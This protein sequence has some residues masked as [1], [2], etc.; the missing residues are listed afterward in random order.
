ADY[1]SGACLAFRRNFFLALGG[2]DARYAPAYYED[3]DLAFAVR[4]AGRKVYYQPAATVVH[5]EG[6]T[7]G[8][9]ASTGVKRH[10]AINRAT[11]R[12]KWQVVLARHRRNGVEP[13]LER[14]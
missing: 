3:T 5:F 12:H 9:D 13:R 2:F 11:F 14:D 10:Q 6:Q 7:S 1:C 4:A 8:T